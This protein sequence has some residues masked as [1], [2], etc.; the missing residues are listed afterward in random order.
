MENNFDS[1]SPVK[2]GRGLPSRDLWLMPALSLATILLLVAGSEVVARSLWP[3]HITDPCR[4]EG[5]GIVKHFKPNCTS[6]LKIPEG[7]YV[8]NV[9][10]ACGYRTRESCGPKAPGAT[11]VAVLGSSS[12]FGYM[13][14]YQDVY[15]TL[16]A[17][18]FSQ[19]YGHRFE[20]EDLGYQDLSMLDIYHQM[21]EAL[22]LKPDLI[23]VVITPKDV[24][25]ETSP[26]AVL[27]RDDPPSL[28]PPDKSE[29]RQ[30]WMNAH[31][32][33]PL[34][35]SRSVYML[36]NTMYH[37]PDTYADLFL[38][39]GDDAGYLRSTLSPQWKA[40]ISQTD[41]LLGEMAQKAAA[42]SVPMV[43]VIVPSTV[44]LALLY[45][46]RPREGIDPK[47]FPEIMEGVASRHKIP[48]ITTI[49]GF[50]GQSDPMSMFYLV[51]SHP[52]KS[53]ERAIA[54]DIESRLP[55]LEPSLFVKC[56]V[57]AKGM[58]EC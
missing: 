54:E 48:I 58:G 30:S 56:P 55:P 34:K 1:Q 39:H 32:V 51:N 35:E 50:A 16:L 2:S 43:M 38:L 12:S 13:N 19:D 14:Q 49:D 17:K 46:D 18:A 40:R 52:Q 47:N 27:H 53:G 29:N 37:R 15:T 22:L 8:K 5:G 36:E 41:M 31:V 26:V 42:A 23:M 33:I 10:N 20:F 4:S 11:R 21:D 25:H 57:H 44:E 3:E 7:P 9:Y 24:H 6:T 45:S 28:A